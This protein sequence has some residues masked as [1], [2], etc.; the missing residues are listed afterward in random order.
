[1]SGS[2]PIQYAAEFYEAKIEPSRCSFSVSDNIHDS[3]PKIL[4]AAILSN[5]V[6][7]TLPKPLRHH[8]ILNYM[9]GH[10]VSLEDRLLAKKGFVTNHGKFVTRHAAVR[11]A[12]E[13]GQLIRKFSQTHGLFSE[14]LW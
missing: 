6:I 1:M 13:A 10:G 2:T 14:D 3:P 5:G 8:D 12:E 7:H 11:I 4:Q 9:K